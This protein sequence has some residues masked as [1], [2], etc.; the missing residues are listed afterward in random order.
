MDYPVVT[1]TEKGSPAEKAGIKEG[2]K[3]KSVNG[4]HI[5]DVLDYRFFSADPELYIQILKPD[6]AEKEVYIAND[7]G[8]DPGISLCYGENGKT[9]RCKNK[10]IFC[11]I[12]QMPP[13]MRDS[14][15]LKDDDVRLSFL[16]GSYITLTNL[17]EDD[18]K[19]IIRQHI[20]P[21][22]VSVHTV[23]PRLR[24]QMLKN[25]HAGDV[26]KIM[27][28]LA[29]RR[30]MMNCQV[31][32]VKGV[33][34][35]K[36]LKKTIGKL[37]KLYPY[38]NSL[39]VVPVGLTKYR[40]KL[41]HLS[42]FEKDDAAEV[43]G[44]IEEF[45]KKA[46]KKH[47]ISFVY[48]SDEF[49]QIA[50]LPLPEEES[51]DGYPQIENGVGMLR[52]FT[53][54][55]KEALEEAEAPEGKREV[56]IITGYAAK[57]LMEETAGAVM[58][59]FPNVK[60]KVYAVK[61]NFFGGGVTVSGLICGCDVLD[62]LSG[63]TLPENILMPEVMFRSGTDIMLDDVTIKELSEKLKVKITK[64][65]TDGFSTVGEILGTE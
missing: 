31:V 48:A 21:V 36:E 7:T 35:K 4:E 40:E 37:L 38:A 54:E 10:C 5:A 57:A 58:R 19:R 25:K 39:S 45:Q 8:E 1:H 52:S 18:I 11:F 43:I 24:V 49:Y 56:G 20:S 14:L 51:Y 46:R 34:D 60:V 6:G 30:I 23:N 44:L 16:T 55:A 32:L 12:D 29:R 42:P 59:K 26:Y 17:T 15:Y 27:K 63:E 41:P 33:N 3:I 50:E 2:D 53:E 47:G 13:G 28:R 62:Q 65:K 9:R 61:N 22:N 64:V